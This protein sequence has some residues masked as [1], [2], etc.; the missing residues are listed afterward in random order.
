MLGREAVKCAF[1]GETGKMMTLTRLS[2][3]PYEVK[4]ETLE[5]EKVADVE[6]I[7]DTAYVEANHADIKDTYMEYILPLIGE[8]PEY[9]EI[10]NME[11][12]GANYVQL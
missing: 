10:N 6:R 11:S 2:S 4:S 9:I 7:M 8:L 12:K 5:L 1:A 3:V